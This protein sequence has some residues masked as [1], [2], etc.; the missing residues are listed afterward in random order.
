MWGEFCGLMNAFE[1]VGL[2]VQLGLSEEG[3]EERVRLLSKE[4]HPDQGGDEESFKEIREAGRRLA[5]PAGRLEVAIEALGGE[6]DA[7]GRVDESL[8]TLF[9]PLAELFGEIEEVLTRR[10]EATSAMG[11]A[12]CEARIP[13]LKGRVEEKMREVEGLEEGFVAD[14]VRWDEAGLAGYL[15]EMGAAARALR[16]TSRWREQLKGAT[17]RLFEALLGG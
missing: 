17:G 12:V 6:F 7:R 11:R 2:P 13:V 5:D 3:L 16:F 14:F 10:K 8:M 1:R 4:A 15:E 9:G